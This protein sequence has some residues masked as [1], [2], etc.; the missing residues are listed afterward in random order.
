MTQEQQEGKPKDDNKSVTDSNSESISD[1]NDSKED[2]HEET[3]VIKQLRTIQKPTQ[4]RKLVDKWWASVIGAMKDLHESGPKTSDEESDEEKVVSCATNVRLL[5]GDLAKEE[6][7][8]SVETIRID[9]VSTQLIDSDGTLERA[10]CEDLN[11]D[12]LTRNKI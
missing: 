4:K 3:E 1:A 12:N 2:P 11:A 5:L 8:E 9:K 10:L 7:G 6:D